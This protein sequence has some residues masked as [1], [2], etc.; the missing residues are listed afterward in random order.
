MVRLRVFER[1]GSSSSCQKHHKTMRAAL[2]RRSKAKVEMKHSEGGDDP[3]SSRLAGYFRVVSAFSRISVEALPVE[4]LMHH[5][6]AQASEATNIKRS[7]VLRYRPDKADLLVEAGVGWNS[8]VVGKATLSTDYRSPP[9][10]A[11]QTA[12]PVVID[13]LP[14]DRD[15][16]YS[17]LLR[18]HGVVSVINVPVMIDGRTWGVLEI[19]TQRRQSFD[20]CDVEFLSTLANMFGSALSRQAA[21]QKGIDALAQN[22]RDKAEAGILLRERQHRVKNNLQ[23]I[24]GFLA[25]KIR[26]SD[27][28]AVREKLDTVIG[29]VQAIAIA[30]DLLSS[31]QEPSSVDFGSYLQALC[32]KLTP[33]GAI[34]IEVDVAH[35]MISLD[36]AVPAGLVVNELITNSLKYA[37]GNGGGII[38]VR[39]DAV[40][41]ASEACISV[42]DDGKGMTLP[43]KKDLA[44]LSSK[45]WLSSCQG[46]LNIRML[47]KVL[48]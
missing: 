40:T 35:E 46:G 29:R 5:L 47:T 34:S 43:L 17:E 26:Q 24:V 32:A 4:R 30:H 16:E 12:A 11:L 39:F 33:D 44:L 18:S 14:H 42:A 37:F 23:I 38:R 36:K 19:D 15:F 31:G 6:A 2:R 10:R 22:E 25:L 20:R 13:D 21:E 8:G 41:N 9:G 27:D 28:A 3:V 45:A 1:F 7:K 48:V